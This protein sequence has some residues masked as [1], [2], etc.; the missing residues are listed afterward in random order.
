MNAHVL[1]LHEATV[2]RW[3][4]RI[5]RVACSSARRNRLRRVDVRGQRG[6]WPDASAAASG[7]TAYRLA[8]RA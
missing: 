6:W 8:P 4:V 3:P 5:A 7:W 1:H 2:D